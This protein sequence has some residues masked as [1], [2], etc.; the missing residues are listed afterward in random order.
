[1]SDETVKRVRYDLAIRAMQLGRLDQLRSDKDWKGGL[2]QWYY[3]IENKMFYLNP[4]FFM[5]LHYEKTS[6][7]WEISLEAFSELIHID[8]QVLWIDCFNKIQ[9][10][11]EQRV[12]IVF[13]IKDQ[14][15]VTHHIYLN[16]KPLDQTWAVPF[17]VGDV[18]DVSD[19]YTKT[20]KNKLEVTTPN[21]MEGDIDPLTGV[22]NGQVFAQRLQ[23]ML[24]LAKAGQQEFSLLL[25]DI[26]F[27]KNIND[28][29]GRDKGDE[30]LKEVGRILKRETRHADFVGRVG[31]DRFEVA[32][33]N[34]DEKTCKM[35]SERIRKAIANH[36]YVGGIRITASGGLVFY[37]HKAYDDL[38]GMAENLLQKSKKGGHNIFSY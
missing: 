8:D 7:P 5:Q 18:F 3:D 21:F 4:S 32:L 13:S 1:M 23:N 28:H 29:F 30:I 34:V 15:D 35:I 36:M 17:I 33:T 26:D 19:Q 14:K 25:V 20:H 2:G 9:L 24:T 12:E 16:G 31:G 38:F 37:N 11:H 6:I 22:L 27:F 10:G